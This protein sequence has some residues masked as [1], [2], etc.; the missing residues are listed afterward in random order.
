MKNHILFLLIL[1]AIPGFAQTATLRFEYFAEMENPRG[2]ENFRFNINGAEYHPGDTLPKAIPINKRGFDQCYAMIEGDTLHFLAKFRKNE[3]YRL[4]PGC[5]CA[6]FDLAP[7]K[8]PRRGTVN[9]RNRT[10]NDVLLMVA[11]HNSD[12][13]AKGKER[14]FYASESAMCMYKPC[15]I[16]IAATAYDDP[17]Y[18]ADF[19]SSEY[20]EIMK[21][22]ES[23]ILGIKRFHFLHGEKIIAG[24][25]EKSGKME[26][27]MEGV[28]TDEEHQKAMHSN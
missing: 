5:C 26:L 22:Q 7:E 4:R 25:D 13:V 17:K 2:W 1:A 20:A 15:S 10:K 24:Y 19:S 14:T 27:R 3:V 6:I 16:V 12:T 8:D 11:G 23:E 18:N 28:L 9:Y 21:A